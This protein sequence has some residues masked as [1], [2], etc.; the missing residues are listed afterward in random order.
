MS[1][2]WWRPTTCPARSIPR[3]IYLVFQDKIFV[4]REHRCRGPDLADGHAE[5]PA[6]RPVVCP[7]VRS[8]PLGT[9]RRRDAAAGSIGRPRVLRRHHPGQRHGRSR[10]VEVE[11]RQ[12]RFRLLN[13]CNARFLNPRLVYATAAASPPAPSPAQ[14]R[15]PGLHPDRHR[16]RIP[17]AP[18]AWSTGPSS[19]LCSWRPPSAPT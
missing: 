13:A 5:L 2:R 15:R 11:P 3:T 1:S 8:G 4:V 7:R 18:G 17:A 19:P 9:W 10:I 16:G 12:Y 6:G 14:R